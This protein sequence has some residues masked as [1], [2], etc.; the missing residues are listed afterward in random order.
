MHVSERYF[1]APNTTYTFITHLKIARVDQ[2]GVDNTFSLQSLEKIIWEDAQ[3]GKI[4]LDIT[5]I[6]EYQNYYLYEVSSKTWIDLPFYADDNL[7]LYAVSASASGLTV[8][9][10]QYSYLTSSWSTAIDSLNGFSNGQ[11]VFPL[12]P[13]CPIFITS[14]INITVATPTTFSWAINAYNDLVYPHTVPNAVETVY[15]PIGSSQATYNLAA[16]NHT[17]TISSSTYNPIQTYKYEINA[18]TNNNEKVRNPNLS[19]SNYLVPGSPTYG[20]LPFNWISKDE[21][22]NDNNSWSSIE[23]FGAPDSTGQINLIPGYIGGAYLYTNDDFGGVLITNTVG[24]YNVFDGINGTFYNIEIEI[25]PPTQLNYLNVGQYGIF[26]P[27][28]QTLTCSLYKQDPTDPNHIVGYIPSGAYGTFNFTRSKITNDNAICIVAPVSSSNAYKFLNN[29]DPNIGGYINTPYILPTITRVSAQ[30]TSSVI[31]NNLTLRVTQSNTTNT[32]TSS[33]IFEPYLASNFRYSDSDV[34]MNNASQNDI[35]QYHRRVLYDVDSVIPSNIEQIISGTAE[36][37][38]VNDYLFNANASVL[39]RYLGVRSESPGVN[40][41]TTFGG[42]GVLPNVES[43]QTYFAY[44]DYITSSYAELLNKSVAHILYLIDKDSNVLVPT[45]SSSYYYNLI[46]NFETNKNVNI[47][48]NNLEGISIIGLKNVLRPGAI[49]WGICASQTGSGL[50][51]Q[52]TMSFSNNTSTVLVPNYASLVNGTSP[53]QTFPIINGGSTTIINFDNIVYNGP[54]TTIS[55]VD[56]DFLIDTTSP[57]VLLNL[58]LEGSLSLTRIYG[59]NPSNIVGVVIYCQESPNGSSWTNIDQKQVQITYGTSTYINLD[60]TQFTAISG[61]YYRLVLY[62]GSGY[63][64]VQ[65]SNGKISLSQNPIPTDA[66][67]V[68]SSYWITGSS[69]KNIL[70]GSQFLKLYNSYKAYQLNYADSGYKNFLEFGPRP[71]DEIRFEGDENQV[72]SI[73]NVTSDNNALYLELDRDIVN[74]T[75]I[76]SFLIRRYEPHPNYI[77]LDWNGSGYTNGDGFLFPEYPSSDLTQNFDKVIIE[78]KEK[79]II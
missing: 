17:L 45:L 69:S 12:T 15:Y 67:I 40:Q 53:S 57:N 2:N 23:I 18:T 66:G 58:K 26:G 48:L 73:Y 6:S 10:R 75:N 16:G 25:P 27:A 43:L 50:N 62:H 78:L 33:L 65:L 5:S 29:E 22:F 38:E 74:G 11:Y 20:D 41:N 47:N 76:N 36:L 44:Y 70:T 56:D 68:T 3:A 1:T 52:P 14:S 37:A 31:V 64:T 60:F 32:A 30:V 8:P 21:S 77:T 34:L 7:L 72:Y 46:D 28:L 63:F 19:G 9:I 4:I 61:K 35:S 39:P 79:G 55:L 71:S 54:E 42:L 59:G 51:I 49:P 24:G 13:N